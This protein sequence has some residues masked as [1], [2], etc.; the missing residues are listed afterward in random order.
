M[1]D[2]NGRDSE[3]VTKDRKLR[4]DDTEKKMLMAQGKITVKAA[5]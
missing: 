2:R 4:R 5:L 3:R 1:D